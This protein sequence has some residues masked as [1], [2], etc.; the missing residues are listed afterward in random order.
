MAKVTMGPLVG[1]IKG[2][3][4]SL[5]FSS[6]KGRA[7]T[8]NM[9]ITVANPRTVDQGRVRTNLANIARAWKDLPIVLKTLWEEYAQTFSG[10]APIGT[11]GLIP[12][13]SNLMSGFNAFQSINT[14]LLNVG[15]ILVSTPPNLSAPSPSLVEISES[16][17]Y[18]F[19]VAVTIPADTVVAGDIVRFFVKAGL[20]GASGYNVYNHLL[21]GGDITPGADTVIEHV[22]HTI[23]LGGGGSFAEVPLMFLQNAPVQVQCDVV[24]ANGGKGAPSGI[25][26]F[27]I[28]DNVEIEIS[29]FYGTVE[30]GFSE[31]CTS[32]VA[33]A[34]CGATE[35]Q[36]FGAALYAC[37]V[38][39]AISWAATLIA[40]DLAALVVLGYFDN[41]AAYGAVDYLVP[42]AGT[43]LLINSWT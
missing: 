42:I 30:I 1:S 38:G 22:I 13:H 37:S 26:S 3:I 43:E 11:G 17:N 2:K 23:K 39:A 35:E 40:A 27:Y 9:P 6:W 29:N 33:L 10:I 15:L 8:K 20:E 5:I 34:S 14:R 21:I 4:G 7:Y 36:I 24:L 18:F 19:K 12:Q 28:S 25:L 16:Y 31:D 32:Y 41:L